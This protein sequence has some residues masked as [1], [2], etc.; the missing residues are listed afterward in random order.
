MAQV[1]TLISCEGSNGIHTFKSLNAIICKSSFKR[2]ICRMENKLQ[3]PVHR[4]LTL[5]HFPVPVDIMLKSV[6]LNCAG[7]DGEAYIL[8]ITVLLSA[9]LQA[10]HDTARLESLPSCG[11]SETPQV[12]H[13]YFC[14][15]T[16]C[17]PSDLDCCDYISCFAA[18]L[19]LL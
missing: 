4:L 13:K 2:K 16:F 8:Y 5:L 6:L 3:A 1:T 11:A 12:W 7:S 19:W 10:V 17:M 9:K 18:W 15:D 14:G